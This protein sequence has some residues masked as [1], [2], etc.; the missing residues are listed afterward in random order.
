MKATDADI[1]IARLQ[2][3]VRHIGIQN[4]RLLKR[5]EHLQHEQQNLRE[6]LRSLVQLKA[7]VHEIRGDVTKLKRLL[8]QVRWFFMG[9]GAA[10]GFLG[11]AVSE[12][13]RG[14]VKSFV[15]G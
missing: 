8:A 3:M 7:E 11:G 13:V 4:E 9:A 5:V 2:E 12:S 15:G 10:F 1:A 6:G 14:A